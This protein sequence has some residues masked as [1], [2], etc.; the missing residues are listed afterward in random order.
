MSRVLI[1]VWGGGLVAG[2]YMDSQGVMQEAAEGLRF[3][4]P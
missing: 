1:G 4:L 2:D 3:V